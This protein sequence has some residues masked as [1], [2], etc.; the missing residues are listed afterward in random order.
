V[1]VGEYGP[2]WV[3]SDCCETAGVLKR[4]LANMFDG[5]LGWK[6]PSG[7]VV[8]SFYSVGLRRC[9]RRTLSRSLLMYVKLVSNAVGICSRLDKPLR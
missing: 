6:I 7:H 5:S 9:G 3:E 8:F 4:L 2:S 1:R